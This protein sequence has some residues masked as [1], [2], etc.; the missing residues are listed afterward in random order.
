MTLVTLHGFAQ[1]PEAFAELEGHHLC[2]LGH[3]PQARAIGGESFVS[4]VD[5][6]ATLVRALVAPD[7][8][9]LLG[10]SLGARLALGIAVRHPGLLQRLSVIGARPGLRTE[11][12]RHERRREDQYWIDL[13]EMRGAEAFAREWEER[14]IF[15]TQ[16]QANRRRLEEQARIRRSHDPRQLARSLRALGL[17]N[18]PSL[19][20]QLV[21]IDIPVRIVVGALDSRFLPIAH[22]MQLHMPAAEVVVVERAGHNC[23]LEQPERTHASFLVPFSPQPGEIHV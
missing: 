16:K 6:L 20:S 9:H 10:Y 12:Q 2:I 3:G 18:M 8:V 4:E 21:R 5:R 22:R 1:S 11:A 19:W 14:E 15:A 23:L 13:L 17:G 7:G